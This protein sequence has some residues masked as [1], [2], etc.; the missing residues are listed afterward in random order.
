VARQRISPTGHFALDGRAGGPEGP[1]F[2]A[3]GQYSYSGPF[4]WRT[5]NVLS[6]SERRLGARLPGAPCT[7][8]I[9][10]RPSM[11]RPGPHV[12]P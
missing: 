1:A 12:Y 5:P 2:V 6:Q 8:A 7:L 10:L 3:N 11:Q 9:P 4:N